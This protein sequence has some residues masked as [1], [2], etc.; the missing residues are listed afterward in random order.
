[1]IKLH[2]LTLLLLGWLSLAGCA[3]MRDNWVSKQRTP[4]QLAQEER[5]QQK[6]LAETRAKKVSFILF[7]KTYPPVD[8]STVNIMASRPSEPFTEIGSL[9]LKSDIASQSGLLFAHSS[10]S[11]EELTVGLK[12]KAASVGADSIVDYQTLE[13][14]DGR[15]ANSRMSYK[16]QVSGIAIKFLK[17]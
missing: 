7:S 11:Y 10:E 1:M 3:G 12:E 4:E 16:R 13:I 9:I 14:P 8:S 5:D 2:Q 15:D 17:K 6:Q